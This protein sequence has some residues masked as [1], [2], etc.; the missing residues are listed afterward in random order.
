MNNEDFLRRR[1]G[2]KWQE[3]IPPEVNPN[4]YLSAN[5]EEES[6]GNVTVESIN[7]LIDFVD[8]DQLAE[9]YL[10]RILEVRNDSEEVL[11]LLV[12]LIDEVYSAA[13]DEAIITDIHEKMDFLSMKKSGA[14]DSHDDSE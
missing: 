1:L 13:E 2:Y 5:N 6:T 14:L 11:S 12:D 10:H 7:A 3:F 8:F 4:K 9:R